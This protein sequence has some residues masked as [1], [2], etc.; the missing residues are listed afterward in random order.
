MGINNLQPIKTFSI[1]LPARSKCEIKA[2]E[3][4]AGQYDIAFNI[5]Y[6]AISKA[7]IEGELSDLHPRDRKNLPFYALSDEFNK[8]NPTFIEQVFK[9]S[10]IN[11]KFVKKI[12][13]AWI[14]H[15]EAQSKKSVIVNKFLSQNKKLMSEDDKKIDAVFK[16]TKGLGYKD[17][18]IKDFIDNKINKKYFDQVGLSSRGLS[19][20]KFSTYFLYQ[21]CNYIRHNKLTPG[22]IENIIK[23]YTN[24]EKIHESLRDSALVSLI[25]SVKSLDI[26]NSITKRIRDIVQKNYEDPRVLEKTWPSIPNIIGGEK[27]KNECIDKVNQWKIFQSIHI[28]FKIIGQVNAPD[29]SRHHFPKRKKF[30]LKYFNNSCVDGAWVAFGKEADRIAQRMIKNNND[31]IEGLK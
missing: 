4:D 7:V 15:Y 19:S 21:S 18:I 6:D 20:R 2:E 12:F 8:Y 22:Q 28:F 29:T 31:E 5:D 13:R 9:K 16:I 26:N 27:Q 14:F 17:S 10:D 25:S 1:Q 23:I 3:L 11:T 24:N 30:W